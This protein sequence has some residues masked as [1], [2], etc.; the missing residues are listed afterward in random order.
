MKP[1]LL[2]LLLP[3]ILAACVTGRAPVYTIE[4]GFFGN[5]RQ[6]H[7]RAGEVEQI[8]GNSRTESNIIG[9]SAVYRVFAGEYSSPQDA[10]GDLAKLK[11]V[12]I[13]A[14]VMAKR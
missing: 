7:V 8:L 11:K 14:R 10:A 12:G 5:Y 3:A 2:V 9:R 13:S 6:A 4:A 1:R